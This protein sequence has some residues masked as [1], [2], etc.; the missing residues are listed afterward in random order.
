MSRERVCIAAL[1]A[2]VLCSA[3]PLAAQRTTETH[4]MRI[5]C[6][7]VIG[8]IKPG[9]AG[10]DE[11]GNAVSF[12][13]AL[14]VK[15]LAPLGITY[16]RLMGITGSQA[17]NLYDPTTRKY[18]WAVLDQSIE[19]VQSQGAEVVVDLFY[20]P[21]WLSSD[22]TGRFWHA[23]PKSMQEWAKYVERIVR[24]VNVEK[25]YGV[26]YWEFW[27]EPSGGLFYAT[28]HKDREGFWR[29]YEATARAIKKAD[30]SALVGGIAD[31]AAFPE[32]YREWYVYCKARNVPVD[33]LTTHWYGEWVR[34]GIRR[35]DMYYHL[36]TN[37]RR[38]HR[39]YYDKDVPILVTEWNL[40]A[41]RGEGTAA[42]Q[43][44]FMGGALFWL[45]ESPATAAMFFRVENYKG[46][47]RSV[48]DEK[49]RPLAT[50]RV[51]KMFTMLPR[52]RVNVA[53]EPAYVTVLAAREKD[54]V[55]A[56][57]SRYDIPRE[58]HRV[59]LTLAFHALREKRRYKVTTCMEDASSG[60]IAGH[61]AARSTE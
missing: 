54:R 55:V 18:D 6:D 60:G 8:Q 29:F 51:L 9:L 28:W 22:P 25:K 59:M 37:M 47:G 36:L 44:A 53:D 34:D 39:Q 23:P 33:F 43:A 3:G 4:E 50:A 41:E 26:K 21:K 16:V 19:N 1:C 13:K 46:L 11:G 40:N 7:Q 48:L 61:L 49:L 15:A 58:E 14:V 17:Y 57:I 31:N 10:V 56:M 35:P 2:A 5:Y 45:Q 32:H 24:H 38:L 52:Q 42:Q 20:M 12:S 27:N 30:P